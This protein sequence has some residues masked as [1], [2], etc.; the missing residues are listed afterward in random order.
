MKRI[1]I[2]IYL[3]LFSSLYSMEHSLFDGKKKDRELTIPINM[4]EPKTLATS[5][6]TS[7][8]NPSDECLEGCRKFNT[9]C[10]VSAAGGGIGFMLGG[11]ITMFATGM[12][13]FPLVIG[14]SS[15]GGCLAGGIAAIVTLY[16]VE[17]EK[18][19]MVPIIRR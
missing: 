3:L 10:G 4:Q 6:Y 17:A 13:L 11:A 12:K 1:G 8:I 5:W 9:I 14:L 2:G 16:Q 7:C 15:G 18:K 19:E